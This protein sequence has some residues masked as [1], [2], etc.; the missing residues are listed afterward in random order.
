MRI[1]LWEPIFLHS[2]FFYFL[3]LKKIGINL[4]AK[5]LHVFILFNFRVRHIHI[6]KFI[7]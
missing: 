4:H 5:N 7:I 6:E 3:N 1:G 2:G